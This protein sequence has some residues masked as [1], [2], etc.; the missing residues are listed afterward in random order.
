VTRALAVEVRRRFVPVEVIEHRGERLPAVQLLRGLGS[1]S[2]HV[3]EEVGVLGEERLLPLGVAAIFAVRVG[4]EELPDRQAV[5]HLCWCD[6]SGAGRHGHLSYWLTGFRKAD[7]VH[8]GKRA[9]DL[10]QLPSRA[11][12]AEVDDEEASGLEYPGDLGVSVIVVA[13]NKDHLLCV[14]DDAQWLDGASVQ[15]LAF[16]ARRLLAESVAIVFAMRVPTEER[17]LAGLP[18]LLG[19]SGHVRGHACRVAFPNRSLRC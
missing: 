17:E 12:A 7:Q 11:Q 16:A 4:I 6:L 15:V 10:L 2:L 14:V 5:S 8:T 13:G 9:A 19:S 18:E 3:D 1:L